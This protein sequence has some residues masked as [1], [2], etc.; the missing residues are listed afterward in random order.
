[1]MP[2]DSVTYGVD[3]NM[4]FDDLPL[5]D[6]LREVMASPQTYDDLRQNVPDGTQQHY[7]R[8]LLDFNIDDGFGYSSNYPLLAFNPVEQ[9]HVTFAMPYEGEEHS[10][11]RSGMTTP[12]GVRRSIGIGNKAFRESIWLWTPAQEDHGYAEQSNLSLPHGSVV[13][14]NDA[15]TAS[16]P[17]EQLMQ[18]ARDRILAS[19]LGTCEAVNVPRVVAC[20]P[21]AELLTVL[22]HNFLEFHLAQ[23]MC[24]IHPATL[25]VNEESA[26]FL[27][28]MISLGAA[29]SSVPELRKL[30]FALQEAMRLSIPE[31]VSL[32]LSTINIYLF[33]S[34]STTTEIRED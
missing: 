15:V 3:P 27:G 34:S 4:T 14:P 10:D 26:E 9:Q 17:R 19:V 7:Q 28:C 20:F 24:F 32:L 11:L 29:I 6:F 30:G 25:H 13:S 21:S 16:Y 12:G 23:D 22:L 18:A 2:L 8:D 1:M 5:L 33:D 31:L